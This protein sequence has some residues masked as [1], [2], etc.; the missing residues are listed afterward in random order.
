MTMKQ[1]VAILFA[2]MPTMLVGCGGPDP[3]MVADTIYEN[4][5]IITIYRAD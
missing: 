1:L 4:G 2:V 3:A 5:D